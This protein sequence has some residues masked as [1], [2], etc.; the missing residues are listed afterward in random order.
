MDRQTGAF[1]FPSPYFWWGVVE[2]RFDPKKLGRVRVRVYG[3][4]TGDTGKMPKDD[5]PWAIPVQ[6]IT[7]A[8][9]SGVGRSPTG[10]VEGTTVFG[11]FVDGPNA[12]VP[13]I[14]GTLAGMNG[15]E[16]YEGGFK[17]PNGKYPRSAGENDVNRL[18]RNERI[19]E[20]IVQKK[21]DGID[22]ADTAFGGTWTEPAT[23]YN[24]KYPFNHVYESESGHIQEWDDTEGAERIGTWHRKGTFEEVDPDG[25]K[26]TKIVKD[27][28]LIVLKDDYVYIK[29]NAKVTIDGNSSLYVKGNADIEVNGNVK[30]HI[31]GN[32]KLNVDGNYDVQVNGHHYDNSNTHRKIV[33]TRVDLNP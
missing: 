32:Y 10:I 4:Y 22:T 17:D 31:H 25:T 14:M 30:E 33:A 1:S 11:F 2:D 5:L 21:R 12:Q 6:G 3:Y 23:K 29:G 15:G 26:I 16:G 27:N 19:G 13:V 7:S 24:A 8:A 28:Y 18:S 9:N 20:T